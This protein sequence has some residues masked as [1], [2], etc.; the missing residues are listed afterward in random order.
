[1]E[2]FLTLLLILGGVVA[3]FIT[4]MLAVVFSMFCLIHFF[5][6]NKERKR[7]RRI[8]N[9]RGHRIGGPF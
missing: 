2:I 8:Q 5:L 7:R 4:L 6:W 9:L 3:L 1:M